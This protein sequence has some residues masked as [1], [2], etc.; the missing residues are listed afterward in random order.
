MFIHADVIIYMYVEYIP[1]EAIHRIAFGILLFP[2]IIGLELPRSGSLS[3]RELP[4]S[5]SLMLER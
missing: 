1:M 3:P 5:D 2:S 4:I